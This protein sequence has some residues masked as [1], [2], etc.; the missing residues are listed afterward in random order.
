MNL[1]SPDFN[2]TL[3]PKMGIIP[4]TVR[5]V[6]MMYPLMPKER[7]EVF[8]HNVGTTVNGG[9]YLAGVRFC[10]DICLDHA[11]GVCAEALDIEKEQ[12]TGPGHVQLQLVV[13]AGMSIE[14]KHTRVSAGGSVLLCHTNR[15][16]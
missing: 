13:S 7:L 8:E 6:Q 9:F 11:R 14:P 10:L 15:R 2:T 4:Q 16:L 3:Y 5:E 1:N 12:G